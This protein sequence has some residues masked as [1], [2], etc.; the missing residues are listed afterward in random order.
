MWLLPTYKTLLWDHV[1]LCSFFSQVNTSKT[2]TCIAMHSE[3]LERYCRK[4]PAEYQCAAVQKEQLC[5]GKAEV[6][7]SRGECVPSMQNN[8]WLPMF[9]AEQP[10][11]FFFSFPPP[12]LHF[13]KPTVVQKRSNRSGYCLALANGSDKDFHIVVI[14]LVWCRRLIYP[15]PVQF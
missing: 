7:A 10:P 14:T 11:V 15:F 6:W 5:V 8:R 4:L 2:R 13:N 9:T 3:A 12:P 1:E